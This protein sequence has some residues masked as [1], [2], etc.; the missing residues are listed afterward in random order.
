MAGRRQVG[1]WI[2][3]LLLSL[4]VGALGWVTLLAAPVPPV[5]GVASLA[6]AALLLSLYAIRAVTVPRLCG[7]TA[8]VTD[9]A[10]RPMP[11]L[12]RLSPDAP[13]RPRPRAPGRAAAAHPC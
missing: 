13:G 11:V 8:S 10:A 12:L 9:P 3:R 6:A 4:A 7:R 1:A 5:A 2:T